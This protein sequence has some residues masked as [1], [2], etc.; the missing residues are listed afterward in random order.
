MA[1]ITIVVN[2]MV[3]MALVVARLHFSLELFFCFNASAT[4]IITT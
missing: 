1:N 3:L 4:N 2:I